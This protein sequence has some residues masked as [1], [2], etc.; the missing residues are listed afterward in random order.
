MGVTLKDVAEAAGVSITAVSKVLHGSGKSVRIAKETETA[1]REAAHRLQYVPNSVARSLRTSRTRTIGLVFE[2]FGSLSEGPMYYVLML[3][4]VA[5]ELFRNHYRLT[6]LAE[7][8]HKHVGG[9]LSD[10]RMDGAIWCKLPMEEEVLTQLAQSRIPVVALNTEAPANPLLTYVSCDNEGGARLV[11]E[12][13]YALGHR[14][15]LYVMETGED[16]TPDAT[17]RLRGFRRACQEAGLPFSEDDIVFWD[18][19][20]SQFADWW[21]SG[22]PHTGVFAWNERVAGAVLRRAHESGVHVPTD[23][24]VVGFDSTPF[25]ETTSPPLTAVRQPIL[26]MAKHAARILFESLDNGP[27]EPRVFTY[28]C[29]LDVRGSTAP[30]S[31]VR[32]TRRKP[33]ET[34]NGPILDAERGHP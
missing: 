10:G 25:C 14:R 12:H 16:D 32:R 27:D 7:V 5:Q 28:P 6:I 11:V 21:R 33:V 3:D 29:T 8:S 1:I 34:S 19:D 31:M 20:A 26:E 18:R 30:T 2:N 4:G 23:L 13:L 24:S 9:A 15:V 17:A 22:P